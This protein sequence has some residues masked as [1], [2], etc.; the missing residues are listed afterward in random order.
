MGGK[1]EESRIL[2][3]SININ[4]IYFM[5]N[6]IYLNT[7]IHMYKYIALLLLACSASA[8]S[9]VTQG[10]YE[11]IPWPYTLCGDGAWTI[12]SLTLDQTPKRNINDNIIVVIY[13]ITQTGTAKDSVAFKRTDILVKLNGVFL[14]KQTAD[15]TDSYDAGDAIEFKYTNFIPNFAPAGT[16]TLNFQFVDTKD[17]NNGCLTFQFKLWLFVMNYVWKK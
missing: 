8:F 12:E 9:I 3:N 11:A 15:F 14:D 7:L 16:Y 2:Y 6:I 17:K 13:K 5:Y 10:G 1:L 4:N